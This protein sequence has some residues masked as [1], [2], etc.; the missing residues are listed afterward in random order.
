MPFLS[1]TRVLLAAVAAGMG[2][3]QAH[4]VIRA[5]A[6]Q[7]AAARRA[8]ND[9]DLWAS[10]G[11]DADFPLDVDRIREA[12]TAPGLAGR[13]GSQVDAVVAAVTEVV[14]T[15]PR[16]ATYQPETLL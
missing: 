7:A 6:R 4:R 12:A 3:E 2:R 5:H 14:D 16:A 15:H 13:A 10:L 11:D 8:G 9:H 1:T